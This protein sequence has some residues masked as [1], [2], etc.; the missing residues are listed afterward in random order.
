[1]SGLVARHSTHLVPNFFAMAMGLGASYGL[2]KLFQAEQLMVAFKT[3]LGA[4]GRPAEMPKP[5]L[6][7]W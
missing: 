3:C 7:T 4:P 5:R 2:H 6:M 1:M